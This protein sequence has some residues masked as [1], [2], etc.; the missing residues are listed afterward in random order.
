MQCYH[1]S[2]LKRDNFTPE[3]IRYAYDSAARQKALSL[4]MIKGSWRD[5]WK[6]RMNAG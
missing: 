3:E 4:Q 5:G 2:K 1:L 6:K